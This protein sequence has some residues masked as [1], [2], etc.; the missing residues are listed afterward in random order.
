M[1]ILNMLKVN[2]T[3]KQRLAFLELLSE[4]K[5]TKDY[6]PKKRSLLNI[7]D[8]FSKFFMYQNTKELF[9]KFSLPS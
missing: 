4:P 8:L 5:P 1:L 9:S 7:L 2:Q 3:N 6:I